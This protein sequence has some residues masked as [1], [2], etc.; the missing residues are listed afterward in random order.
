MAA[1]SLIEV[2]CQ[3]SKV[4]FRLFLVPFAPHKYWSYSF[5]CG[6]EW[7]AGLLEKHVREFLGAFMSSERER[8]YNQ[9]WRD[10]KSHHT[11]KRRIFYTLLGRSDP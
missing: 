3:G 2:H 7:S 6:A 8:W 10:A 4:E 1:Q 11:P 5:E 9:G